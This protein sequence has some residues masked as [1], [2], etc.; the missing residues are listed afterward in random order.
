M[1]FGRFAPSPS[2]RLH[3]GS[4]YT[5]LA[6]TLRAA[7]LGGHCLTRI[8]DLDFPRCSPIMTPWMLQELALL[9][10][11]PYSRLYP[12]ASGNLDLAVQSHNMNV[13]HQEIARLYN[14][15]HAYCCNCTRAELKLH[16]CQ[17]RTKGLKPHLV[18]APTTQA[19]IPPTNVPTPQ[20]ST[21]SS[22]LD[23]AP[24]SALAPTQP[25]ALDQAPSSVLAQATSSNVGQALSSDAAQAVSD[26]AFAPTQAF[27]PTPDL[28]YTSGATSSSAS[29]LNLSSAP[30][31][32]PKT[33]SSQ[34]QNQHAALPAS[35]LSSKNQTQSLPL[36]DEPS[37]HATQNPSPTP[38][39]GLNQGLNQSQGLSQGPSLGQG[40]GAL[41]S[42]NTPGKINLI[43]AMVDGG[44]SQAAAAEH[45]IIRA[46]LQQYLQHCPSFEDGVFG[47]VKQPSNLPSS[48]ILQRRD[49]IIAYNLA[50]VVDDHRQGITEIVRGA[51]LLETTFLQLALYEIC[52]YTPPQFFHVPLMLDQQGHKLSKQNY[53]PAILGETLPHLCTFEAYQRLNQQSSPLIQTI[54]SQQ[55]KLA[56]EA[57]KLIAPLMQLKDPEINLLQGNGL[58]P[59]YYGALCLFA[60]AQLADPNNVNLGVSTALQALPPCIDAQR[61]AIELDNT[62]LNLAAAD[63][64]IDTHLAPPTTPIPSSTTITSRPPRTKGATGDMISAQPSGLAPNL[65]NPPAPGPG[66]TQGADPG[67]VPD[68]ANGHAPSLAQAQAKAQNSAQESAQDLALCYKQGLA[69]AP[70]GSSDQVS[71]H[72]WANGSSL[73]SSHGS[74]HDSSHGLARD[75]NN[76]APEWGEGLANSPA[77]DQAKSL[78]AIPA[79]IF[80][81]IAAGSLVQGFKD[82]L[83][84]SSAQMWR[85]LVSLAHDYHELQLSLIREMASNFDEHRLQQ[86]VK[87]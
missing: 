1:Y 74:Y 55:D 76:S 73:G 60:C 33:S 79:N 61:G 23:Q 75:G 26:S 46:E 43:S 12:Q 64:A 41:N 70:A 53:A 15:A 58:D 8:E 83:A 4:L 62:N 78:S 17:C 25:S 59:D 31:L 86:L 27:I 85:E 34:G 56:Q 19:P 11:F 6:A 65:A 40:I 32:H 13:Y 3:F 63:H 81:N 66:A 39:L 45:L 80:T 69:Q 52:G 21:M 2:G 87:R 72:G 22:A 5:G 50:V 9:G 38:N 24:F 49:G 30:S 10:L 16:A 28:A 48:L 71:E 7:S 29:A 14:S 35:R 37:L 47:Q 42:M 84:D 44:L 20:A 57:M 68:S 36:S 18:T 67:T 54:V 77:Q 82:G 51:D